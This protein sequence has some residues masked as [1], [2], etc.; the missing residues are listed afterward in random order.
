MYTNT[1]YANANGFSTYNSAGTLIADQMPQRGIWDTYAR[2]YRFYMIEH[3]E[4]HFAPCRQQI[5]VDNTST[6]VSQW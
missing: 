5:N 2:M 4:V 3:I 6:L 1:M